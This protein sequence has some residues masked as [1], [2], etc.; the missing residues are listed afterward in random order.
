MV[1]FCKQYKFEE[2]FLLNL[3][4]T[5]FFSIPFKSDLGYIF[6]EMPKLEPGKLSEIIQKTTFKLPISDLSLTFF[7]KQMENKFAQ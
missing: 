5:S 6:R 3:F 1:K 4:S 7:Y 2:M